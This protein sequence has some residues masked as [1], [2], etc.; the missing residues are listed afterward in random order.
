MREM[1]WSRWVEDIIYQIYY[2]YD[3]KGLTDQQERLKSRC[4]HELKEHPEIKDAIKTNSQME[5]F[6]IQIALENI[7]EGE[8]S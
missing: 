8:N 5:H 3:L 2:R 7:A 1:V 6:V 4:L